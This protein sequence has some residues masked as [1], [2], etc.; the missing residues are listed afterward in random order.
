MVSFRLCW[1]F[2]TA[3]TSSRIAIIPPRMSV[4]ILF[5]PIPANVV[6]IP[7]SVPKDK[8]SLRRPTLVASPYVSRVGCVGWL[9]NFWIAFLLA[10]STEL[11]LVLA[12]AVGDDVA[13]ADDV[14]TVLV[15]FD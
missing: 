4:R 6:V 1:L 10:V 13:D 3:F 8:V 11:S 14:L 5:N 15:W 12:L 9:L 7:V 2:E